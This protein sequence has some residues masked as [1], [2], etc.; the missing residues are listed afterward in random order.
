MSSLL[1]LFSFTVPSR[2]LQVGEHIDG[3][4]VAR[5]RGFDGGVSTLDVTLMCLAFGVQQP[6]HVHECQQSSRSSPHRRS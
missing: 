2:V 4:R 3:L 5:F 1:L 6:V